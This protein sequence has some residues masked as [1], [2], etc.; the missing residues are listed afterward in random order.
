MTAVT[1]SWCHMGSARCLSHRF[2]GFDALWCFSLCGWG[3]HMTA[4]HPSQSAS[5]WNL[6][7]A[8]ADLLT[9]CWWPTMGGPHMTQSCCVSPGDL[10]Y[11]GGGWGTEILKICIY[12]YDDEWTVKSVSERETLEKE[13]EAMLYELL[14]GRKELSGLLPW[15][16]N[17]WW[18]FLLQSGDDHI[19]WLRNG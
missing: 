18:R 2:V 15:L 5:H 14:E 6:L 12:K 3:T 10:Q 13:L 1:Y 11:F 8:F 16:R 19:G 17:W 7:P 9:K 4:C